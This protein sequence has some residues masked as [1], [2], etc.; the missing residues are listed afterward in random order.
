MVAGKT[1]DPLL[2]YCHWISIHDWIK[3]IINH[4]LFL[5]FCTTHLLHETLGLITSC[6]LASM[7]FFFML[8]SPWRKVMDSET[9]RQ[10]GIGVAVLAVIGVVVLVRHFSAHK[11]K[12]HTLD[13]ESNVPKGPQL[14]RYGSDGMTPHHH[15]KW[16]VNPGPH[17]TISFEFRVSKQTIPS[18]KDIFY[19]SLDAKQSTDAPSPDTIV[20]GAFHGAYF[21]LATNEMKLLHNGKE[22]SKSLSKLSDGNWHS[23]SI[24]Y[25]SDQMD[26]LVD[27][28]AFS[29][30][31]IKKQSN[32]VQEINSIGIGA[33]AE[34]AK[35]DVRGFTL[36][37]ILLNQ[38][39]I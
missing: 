36:T 4:F 30:L 11:K 9:K 10:I 33:W 2:G 32:K 26:I 13:R 16:V 27:S 18:S 15:S 21:N 20:S 28:Q 14:A 25:T 34:M 12:S 38:N 24:N 31:T 1:I 39:D 19:V 35:F 17:W 5:C 8:S 37:S 23:V 22:Q 3:R 29:E 7:L 6:F